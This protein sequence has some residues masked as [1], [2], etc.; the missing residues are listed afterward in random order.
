MLRSYQV[1]VSVL[2]ILVISQVGY[3]FASEAVKG[4]KKDVEAFKQEMAV[5]LDS[6]EKQLEE[7]RI[8]T[9]KK[10]TEIQENTVKDLELTRNKLRKELNSLEDST[11]TNWKQMKKDFSESIDSFH[12]KL[13]K[14]L[15]D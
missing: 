7:L 14:A 15:K 1:F 2:L 13:Q 3:A 9:K 4:A 12:A 11:K 10:S 8:K 6:V 5:K